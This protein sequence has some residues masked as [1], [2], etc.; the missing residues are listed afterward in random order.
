M[1]HQALEREWQWTNAITSRRGYTNAKD[2]DPVQIDRTGSLLEAITIKI[3]SSS[4]L[5]R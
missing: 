1:Y 4:T 3:L 5:D 2:F